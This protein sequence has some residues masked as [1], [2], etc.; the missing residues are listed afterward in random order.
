VSRSD[1]ETRLEI[2]RSQADRVMRQVGFK[3]ASAVGLPGKLNLVR[4]EDLVRWLEVHYDAAAQKEHDRLER[5]AKKLE[6]AKHE[7]PLRQKQVFW[8]EERKVVTVVSEGFGAIPGLTLEPPTDGRPGRIEVLYTGTA[9]L[10]GK[11]Q[12]IGLAMIGHEK[13]FGQITEPVSSPKQE[14]LF[15]SR[16][17]GQASPAAAVGP[18]LDAGGKE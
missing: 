8:K 2:A 1:I 5:L 9:D 3:P 14:S 6:E 18:V 11:W 4:T 7:A 16:I 13:Y 12:L 15:G 17:N 10:V